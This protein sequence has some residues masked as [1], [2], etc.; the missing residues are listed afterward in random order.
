[1]ISPVTEGSQTQTKT[2]N[3]E[4]KKS[5]EKDEQNN[6]TNPTNTNNT[7]QNNEKKFS[8][9]NTVTS[10]MS[11]KQE[12]KEKEKAKDKEKENIN[13]NQPKVE[14]VKEQ[15]PELDPNCK[16]GGVTQSKEINT[17]KPN[18]D[19]QKDGLVI[20]DYGRL[21]SLRILEFGGDDLKFYKEYIPPYQLK[22]H[23][24]NE[25]NL[26]DFNSESDIMGKDLL[27]NK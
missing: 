10:N 26:F 13:Q 21:P 3:K 24:F 20:K 12:K 17:Y 4:S 18:F 14:V 27:M 19:I 6:N 5:K 25:T 15:E 8:P 23:I 1:M 22:E 7:N 11:G 2:N 9:M 16:I